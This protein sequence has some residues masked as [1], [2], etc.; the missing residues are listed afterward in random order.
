MLNEFSR[1]MTKMAKPGLTKI[2]ADIQEQVSSDDE[3]IAHNK[4]IK[5]IRWIS[6]VH[7]RIYTG[8]GFKWEGLKCKVTSND[9]NVKS[10]K[11]CEIR[12]NSKWINIKIS[13]DPVSNC[14]DLNLIAKNQVY[15]TY[16]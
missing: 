8:H 12:K 10:S 1:R 16:W 11:T 5:S 13:F 7:L 4:K 6:K 15:I 2:L 3:C 14:L 9:L